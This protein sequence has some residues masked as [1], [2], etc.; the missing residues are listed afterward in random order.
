MKIASESCLILHKTQQNYCDRCK[1]LGHTSKETEKCDSYLVEED[2]DRILFKYD[3]DP[4]SNFY[5]CEVKIQGKIFSSSKHA[6]Q[7]MKA[8]SLGHA[9]LTE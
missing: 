3:S 9:N 8:S 7:W 1:E 2:T 6:Y 5:E 4:L